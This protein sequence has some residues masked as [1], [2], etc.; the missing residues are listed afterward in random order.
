MAALHSGVIAFDCGEC[1]NAPD[2]K[3]E[4]ACEIPASNA[5]WEDGEN[6]FYNCP[7]KFVT[8]EAVAWYQEHVYN[9]QYHT[10]LPYHQQSEG[11]IA[12][13]NYYKS[14]FNKFMKMKRVTEGKIHGRP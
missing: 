14:A 11:Y 3:K 8:A 12:A 6:E 5:V 7:L 9:E 1:Q 4:W 10:A 13:L 2:L